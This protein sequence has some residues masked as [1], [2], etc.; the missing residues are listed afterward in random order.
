[1]TANRQKKTMQAMS[2]NEELTAWA[3]KALAVLLARLVRLLNEGI[4]L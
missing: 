2:K 3:E 4:K 1:M